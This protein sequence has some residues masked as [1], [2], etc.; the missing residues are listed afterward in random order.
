MADTVS[1]KTKDICDAL[2]IGRHQLRVWADTLPPYC[3]R[4]TKERSA[5]RYDPADLLYFA[6]I[7]Y[8]TNNFYLS[9]PFITRFSEELY[10]CIREPQSLTA[11][12]F[13]FISSKGEACTRLNIDQV[14]QEGIVVNL[15]PAQ[16]LVYQFLGLSPQQAQLPLDLMEVN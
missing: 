13:I 2:K 11:N 5:R 1:L 6:V 7:Q 16:T 4:E 8:I 3:Q 12:P 14:N 10:S 15:Q 9:L